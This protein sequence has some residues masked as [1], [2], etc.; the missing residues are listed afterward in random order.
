MPVHHRGM[1][2]VLLV[3]DTRTFRDGRKHSRAR[4]SAEALAALGRVR[5]YGHGQL[6]LDHDLGIV[7]GAVDSTPPV[8]DES[9]LPVLDELARAASDGDPYPF[10]LVVVHTSNPVGAA[11]IMQVLERWGYASRRVPS[12]DELVDET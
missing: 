4:T 3:D 12:A 5:D 6:W 11:T 1:S 9:T 7:D 2:F 10:D 8:L